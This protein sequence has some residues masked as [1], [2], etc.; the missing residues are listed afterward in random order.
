MR[1]Q[2]LS[3]LHAV[4]RCLGV[5]CLVALLAA[6]AAAS[7]PWLPAQ[8][9][10]LDN[11]LTLV[12]VPMH[13]APAVTHMVWYRVGA[14]DEPAGSKGIAHLLEHLMF[15]GTPANPDGTFS[16]QVARVGGRENAFTSQDYTAYFQTVA[17][18]QLRLVMTLE[19]DRMANLVLDDDTVA[20][21]RQVVLEERRQRV[22]ASPDGRLAEQMD[23]ALYAT[24]PYSIPIIGPADQIAALTA[25]DALSFYRR[26]YDPAN[27]VVVVAGDTTLDEALS[28]ARQTY[29]QVATRYGPGGAPPRQRPQESMASG[30]A[31]RV[32]VEDATVGQASW[33][34]RY[35][36]PAYSQGAAAPALEVAAYALGG[37]TASLLHR[38][39]VL[40]E[41]LALSAGASYTGEQLDS[42]TL[43]LYA[44]PA[45][46]VS[47]D[48]VEARMDRL[49]EQV[50]RDGFTD[51]QV[52]RAQRRL[53]DSTAYALDS[54]FA[55]ARIVGSALMT[56]QSLSDVLGWPDAILA[57]DRP[58]AEAAFD[59]VLQHNRSVTGVLLPAATGP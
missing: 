39:L 55:P 1:L 44:T 53:V 36:A 12:V 40:E 27:A 43:T 50:V 38:V 4:W 17:A 8:S 25:A 2:T 23:G 19:A 22:D 5:L 24:H 18:D 54:L 14:A 7:D 56:G 51:D 6:P 20:P 48:Q 15:K 52:R 47:L 30:S 34:R 33:R 59:Q 32:S 29:G 3:L 31:T 11:G 13:R 37:D 26:W 42:G 35:L 49:L 16:R 41:G 21:E 46:G 28:L 57:V 9:A 10:T 45:D 58:S